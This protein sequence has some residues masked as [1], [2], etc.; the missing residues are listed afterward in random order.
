MAK[1]ILSRAEFIQLA[2]TSSTISREVDNSDWGV[3]ES[4]SDEAVISRFLELSPEFK[5]CGTTDTFYAEVP[6]E[7]FI[8]VLQIIDRNVGDLARIG[9][10]IWM[11]IQGFSGS[12]KRIGKEIEAITRK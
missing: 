3:Y 2:K 10:G 11:M 9:K 4:T 8:G 12:L 1:I 6:A 5:R 7:Q